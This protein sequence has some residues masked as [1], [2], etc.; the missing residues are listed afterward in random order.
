MAI[1]LWQL[2][3]YTGLM[4]E[5]EKQATAQ[6]V[7]ATGKAHFLRQGHRSSS[8]LSDVSVEYDCMHELGV[9]AILITWNDHQL[10]AVS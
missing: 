6:P 8:H 5:N 7:H 10:S 9:T 1:I 2:V 3:S 4:S